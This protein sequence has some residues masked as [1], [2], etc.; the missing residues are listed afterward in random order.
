M[1]ISSVATLLVSATIAIQ[2]ETAEGVADT[3]VTKLATTLA[4]AIEARTGAGAV[5]DA[6]PGP[7]CSAEDRCLNDV[8]TRTRSSE[9][10]FVTALGVPT[11]IRLVAE[12]VQTSWATSRKTQLDLSR[13]T[14]TW[15]ASMAGLAATLFPEHEPPPLPTVRAPAPSPPPPIPAAPVEADSDPW[16]WIIVGA[17]AATGVVGVLAGVSSASARR[18]VEAEPIASKAEQDQLAQ[19]AVTSALVAN[20][21]FVITAAGATTAAWMLWD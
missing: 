15:A 8:L 13:Q 5:L 6:I 19:R 11:R 18:Q 17:T 1:L 20:V 2:V 9:V 16:P 3:D 12:R 10:V 21:L 14:D 4:D 7:R